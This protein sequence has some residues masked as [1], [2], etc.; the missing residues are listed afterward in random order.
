[1]TQD[2]YSEEHLIFRDAFRKYV[3]KEIVPN[4]E[5]WEA[6]GRI[7]RSAWTKLAEQGYLCPWL[8]EEYGGL[9][10]DFLY[11]VIICEELTRVRAMGFMVSLHSD[12]V[13]PYLNSFGNE[14]Q[15]KKY[16][17]GAVTG[18]TLVA[19]AMT[20]PN[21]GSDLQAIRT[22]AVKDGDEYV[23][24]GQKTF[25]SLGLECDLVIVAAKTDPNAKPA[26]KGISL[27]L[28]ENGAPGFIKGR[29]LDKMGWRMSDTSELIFEDC[30]IPAANLLGE[31]NKGF[32]YL[33]MKLQQERLVS[34]M[35]NQSAAEAILDISVQYSK[36][37]EAF[38]TP[39]GSLQH[40]T[41][42]LAEMA[43]EVQL[44]RTFLNDLI[45]DH[46]KGLDIV[47]K[48]SMAKWWTSEMVNRVAYHGVQ[49]HGGYGYMEE[50]P[51]CAWYRDVR[52]LSIFAGTT[53][54]MK[55]IIGKSMGF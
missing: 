36:E 52:V 13:V 14:E 8:P 3:E 16:L 32:L 11:S 48:V 33:M 49:L 41:F 44:G 53:E 5:E 51:I 28:V 30:R 7:P 23:I 26:H 38:G 9:D 54:V 43:T 6:G 39:I 2:L 10:A 29:K 40:N 34:S 17:P 21:T 42:K 27:L 45:D 24:N 37:R 25:I 12:I 19:V 20:E 35:M 50:Y 47:K 1:M 31:E 22:T 18:E 15:K 46:I 55:Q 4:L